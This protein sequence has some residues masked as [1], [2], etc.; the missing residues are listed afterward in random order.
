MVIHDKTYAPISDAIKIRNIPKGSTPENAHF[1]LVSLL[2]STCRKM[3]RVRGVRNA[4]RN[5]RRR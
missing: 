3:K 5:T 1:Q 2:S 4:K